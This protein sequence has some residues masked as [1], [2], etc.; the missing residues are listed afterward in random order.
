M[1]LS[2]R[3]KLPYKNG[4]QEVTDDV[5]MGRI[6]SQTQ[7]VAFDC[8]RRMVVGPVIKCRYVKVDEHKPIRDMPDPGKHLPPVSRRNSVQ[9][10][11]GLDK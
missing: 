7:F 6:L 11:G 9:R 10:E 1:A 8:I 2:C 5:G 3:I 4:H